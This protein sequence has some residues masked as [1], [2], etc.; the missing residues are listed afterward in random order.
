MEPRY[1]ILLCNKNIDDYLDKIHVW[2]SK[3]IKVIWFGKPNE[4]NSLKEE[5]A[6]FAKAFLLLGY[7]VPFKDEKVIVDGNDP[8]GFVENII[9]EECPLFNSAQYLV[10]H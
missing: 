9:Q 4:V 2:L 6:P 5:Y 10:E 8:D 3:G 7:E 1:S